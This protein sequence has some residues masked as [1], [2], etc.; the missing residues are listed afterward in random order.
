[1]NGLELT[2]TRANGIIERMMTDED[3][4]EGALYEGEGIA[5]AHGYFVCEHCTKT[6]FAY[7]TAQGTMTEKDVVIKD[8]KVG[9]EKT[10]VSHFEHHHKCIRCFTDFVDFPEELVMAMCGY[11]Q[12]KGMM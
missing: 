9:I 1:M 5:I 2:V 4:R 10:F 6:L 7:A 3:V 11:N 12:I 8:G